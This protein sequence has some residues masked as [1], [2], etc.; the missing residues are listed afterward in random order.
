MPT[1]LIR[2]S[3]LGDVVLCAGVTGEIGEVVFLTSERYA[4][5]VARF[6]GVVEVIGMRPDEPLSELRR[7]LPSG[8]PVLDLH[9]SLRSRALT[10]G[11][12]VRRVDGARAGRRLRVMFKRP[13]RIPPVVERYAAAAGVE[14]AP[15]PWISLGERGQALGLAPGAAHATK[16][17]GAARFAELGRAWG[18]PV[19]VFGAASEAPLLRAVAEGCGAEVVAEQGFDDTLAGLAGC[20]AFVGGDTGLLHLAAACGLPVVGVFGPTH[21]ADGFWCHPGE[22]VELDLPCRPCSPFGGAECLIGDHRCMRALEP[23]AVL[24]ALRRVAP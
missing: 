12:P 4:P 21:S 5:L 22:V 19:R 17:W 15:R 1:L 20:A 16:R 11:R 24:A 7:R 18:G 3:S 2:F 8:L 6:P 10:L 23:A 14:V 13:A 9:G